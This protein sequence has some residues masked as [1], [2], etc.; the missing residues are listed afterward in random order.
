MPQKCASLLIC[1]LGHEA[2][3]RGAGVDPTD[4]HHR[5][6]ITAV[7]HYRIHRRMCIITG[8]V[9][10]KASQPFLFDDVPSCCYHVPIHFPL[11]L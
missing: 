9:M 1:F 8:V 7:M 6:L 3:A 2:F 4:A 5:M 10:G 11:D